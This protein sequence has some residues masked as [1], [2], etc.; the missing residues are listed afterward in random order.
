MDVAHHLFHQDSCHILDHLGSDH[1]AGSGDK[2][3]ELSILLYTTLMRRA[4]QDWYEQGDI[5]ARF[6]ENRPCPPR[7]SSTVCAVLNSTC[8]G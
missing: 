6:A 8:G 7:R 5:W 2:R 4:G 1:A 3:R